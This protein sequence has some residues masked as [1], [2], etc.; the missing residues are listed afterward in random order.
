[1]AG[2]ARFEAGIELEMLRGDRAEGLLALGLKLADVTLQAQFFGEQF[3]VLLGQLGVDLLQVGLGAG[4]GRLGLI[5]SHHCFQFVILEFL[6]AFL[7]GQD[8]VLHILE[9]FGVAHG[10][11]VEA[12]FGG[13]LLMAD[14]LELLFQV[15]LAGFQ[16]FELALGGLEGGLCRLGSLRIAELAGDFRQALAL[17]RQRQFK[18]LELVEGLSWCW[19]GMFISWSC[20]HGWDAQSIMDYC[21]RQ[22]RHLPTKAWT[23]QTTLTGYIVREEWRWVAFVSMCLIVMAFSPLFLAARAPDSQGQFMGGIHKFSDV[24]SYLSRMAQ[25]ADG[26]WLVH[27]QHTPE[28]H[29]S[30]L[31]NPLYTALGHLSRWTIEADIVIFHVGRLLTS[32]LMYLSL[33]QL[34]ATIWV[35]VRSRRI[36]FILASLG[37]GLGW[38]LATLSGETWSADLRFAQPFP[39]FG[40]L[41]AVHYP[42]AVALLALLGATS[43]HIFRPMNREWPSVNNLGVIGL[44]AGLALSFVYPETIIPL[45]LAFGATSLVHW[46]QAR[47]VQQREIA[48]ASWL[49]IPT[50]PLAAYYFLTIL[51][52]PV[53]ATWIQ[54]NSLSSEHA[55]A[56]PVGVSLLLALGLP[57]LWRALRR[58]EADTDRFMLLWL[59]AMLAAFYLTAPL[60]PAFLTALSLPLAYFATRSLEDVWLARMGRRS[61]QRW[62][63][64]GVGLLMIGPLYITLVPI[65]P[66]VQ[67]S[68]IAAMPPSAYRSAM[69][70]LDERVNDETVILASPAVSVWIPSWTGAHAVYGHETETMQPQIK[71]ELVQ[72]WYQAQ[73]DTTCRS[74]RGVQ[75]SPF[76]Y[77]YVDFVLYGP[78]ERDLGAGDC[79]RSLSLIVSFDDV[80]VY[81]CDLACK[82]GALS[83]P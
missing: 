9:F 30:A 59:L 44:L 79:L 5:N 52:N 70:W 75:S 16:E 64:L 38:L 14:S 28:T 50:V 62:F 39:Y 45:A 13:L 37:M 10:A 51:R 41:V 80:D 55:L 69:E 35:R 6:I 7:E 66:L 53:I 78:L 42:L 74:L 24:S 21:R 56:L 29:R 23:M 65:V 12:F 18:V 73:D 20:W 47:Q 32:L 83:A 1:V 54:Q 58:L 63:I 2:L 15:A 22:I 36:F 25:G 31:V 49:F 34:A 68:P 8:F 26:Q 77:Y 60:R 33:Y 72:R 11:A 17:A 67:G 82:L 3:A 4:E 27:L 76:G 19:H 61:R 43:I 40:T 48:W 57:A 81:V 46:W 71:R